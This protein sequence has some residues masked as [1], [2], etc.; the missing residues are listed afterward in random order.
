M[1]YPTKMID[2]GENRW[3]QLTVS[4]R[5]I[6]W[7]SS[8]VSTLHD[9]L[10]FAEHILET[11]WW[12][13]GSSV[14]VREQEMCLWCVSSRGA[15]ACSAFL[16]QIWNNWPKMEAFYTKQEAPPHPALIFHCWC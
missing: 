6:S 8:V 16:T 7:Q 9:E 11:C 3:T 12:E 2:Q 13:G 5:F 14:P 15:N 4:D 1:K 10:V